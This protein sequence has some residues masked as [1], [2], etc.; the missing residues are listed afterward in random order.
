MFLCVY[1]FA[2]SLEFP[3]VYCN[4]KE[5]I[6]IQLFTTR[7]RIQFSKSASSSSVLFFFRPML[8]AAVNSFH[9]HR[10][11]IRC[12]VF[13]DSRS[14]LISLRNFHADFVRRVG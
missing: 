7:I 11:G 9:L 8:A 12:S 4:E 6:E 13:I 1:I 2:C 14:P 5:L 3:A 10:F